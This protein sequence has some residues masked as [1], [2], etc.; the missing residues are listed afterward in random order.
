MVHDF[1]VTD[2]YAIFMD[3]CLLFDPQAS[4]PWRS[5]SLMRARL[6]CRSLSVA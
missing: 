1:A 6:V 5:T 4:R 3:L 2:N